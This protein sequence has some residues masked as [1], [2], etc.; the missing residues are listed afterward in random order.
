VSVC[1]QG[2][3]FDP[4]YAE[5]IFGAFQRLHGKGEYPGT[6]IGLAICKRIIEG[7]GGRIWAEARPGTGAAFHFTLPES[8]DALPAVKAPAGTVSNGSSKQSATK[9]RAQASGGLS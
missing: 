5:K 4:K 2:I 8:A 7:H 3:G 6:G 9:P 1:D